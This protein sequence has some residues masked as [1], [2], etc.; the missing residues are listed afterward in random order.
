MKYTMKRALA[1]LI[2]LLLALPNF[3]WAEAPELE[4]DPGDALDIADVLLDAQADLA[5]DVQADLAELTDLGELSLSEP[6][7]GPMATCR[8]IVD[9]E[10]YASCDV[11]DGDTIYPPEDPASPQGAAFEGWF[12][13]EGVRRFADGVEVARVD[14]GT[15]TLDVYARFSE[16]EEDLTPADDRAEEDSAPSAAPEGAPASAEE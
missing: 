15:L 10:V 16:A 1:L 3:A 4:I 2:A 8:F 14:A 11:R 6:E 7:A 13:G 12:D 9:G 5:L